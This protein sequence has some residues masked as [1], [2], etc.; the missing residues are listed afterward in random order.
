MERMPIA[1]QSVLPESKQ[2]LS[3][4]SKRPSNAGESTRKQSNKAKTNTS[5]P[6]TLLR[7]QAASHGIAPS[8]PSMPNFSMKAG[9]KPER[10]QS[11]SHKWPSKI[12][13]RGAR[14]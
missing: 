14:S 1:A 4:N 2:A 11:T 5:D 7:V 10:P 13:F 3:Y 8:G 9:Y 6:T 12:M